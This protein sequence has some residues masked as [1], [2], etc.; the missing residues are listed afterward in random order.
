M[1][2]MKFN[3]DG[4]LI[5]TIQDAVKVDILDVMDDQYVSRPV[6]FAPRRKLVE[7]MQ[8]AS[9]TGLVDYL[10]RNIDGTTRKGLFVRV[11]DPTLVSTHN[12]VETAIDRRYCPLLAKADLPALSL[13]KY[14]ER[15]EVMIM[16]Q[17]RF[18]DTPERKTLLEKLGNIAADEEL[19]QED[20][21]VSQTVTTVKGVRRTPATIVNPV[22]LRP[23]RTFTEVEQPESPF[24]I[25]LEKDGGIRVALFEADG[26][27]WRNAARLAIKQFIEAGLIS[28][29]PA[30]PVIA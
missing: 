1:S 20:D 7:T 11:D 5:G 29:G 8:V 10:N 2:E 14:I 22:M 28:A 15:E 21:G 19:Q 18:V 12:E 27:A 30:I 6:D 13:N 25:R 17:A 24:I 4:K 23:F 16:L 3:D 26:G 9:L